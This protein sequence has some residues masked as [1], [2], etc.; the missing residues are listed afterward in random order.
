MGG[1]SDSTDLIE[2]FSHF[3][4]ECYAKELSRVITS[5]EKSLVIDYGE[6]D[7][8]DVELAEEL[9][10]NPKNCFDAFED[11]LQQAGGTQQRL[12]VR[13]KNLPERT[14]FIKIRDIISRQVVEKTEKIVIMD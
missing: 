3:I 2:S 5:G 10:E 6:L 13:F 8:Y 9:L 7:K 14:S 1:N 4:S 12:F 11:A